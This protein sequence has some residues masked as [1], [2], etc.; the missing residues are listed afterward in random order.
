[1]IIFKPK[2][3][4]IYAKWFSMAYADFSPD[5]YLR[6]LEESTD[7]F[8]IFKISFEPPHEKSNNFHR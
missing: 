2:G 7:Y 3:R 1:M 4:Y 8:S 6:H 5:N